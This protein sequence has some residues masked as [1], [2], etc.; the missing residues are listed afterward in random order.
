MELPI[1]HEKAIEVLKSQ[2]PEAFDLIH[3]RMS[4]AV[5]RE[6]AKK[7]DEDED[8]WGMLGLLHDVDW[9]LTKSN[10]SEHL[11]KAP[12][13]LRGLGFDDEFV[14]IVLSHGYG[15]EELPE[16]KNKVR[17]RKIEWALAA[18]ETLTGLIYAYALMRGKRV[19]DMEVKGLRKKFKDKAFA[20]GCRRDVISE[21]E[22]TGLTLDELFEAG[23]EGI[24]KIKDEIGLQ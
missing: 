21:I 18:S 7:L 6:V 12:E 13:I 23:I 16:L 9:T 22:K 11:T 5:M 2:N 3:Y 4:E 10:V 8:Y 15:F 1:S 24:K 19:S 14:K 20:A 17:E